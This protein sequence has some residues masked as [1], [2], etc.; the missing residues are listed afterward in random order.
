MQNSF[1]AWEGIWHT[2]PG[3]GARAWKG[4]EVLAWARFGR[5]ALEVIIVIE[6]GRKPCAAWNH[7]ARSARPSRAAPVG[8]PHSCFA[9]LPEA[10]PPRP[11]HDRLSL[12]LDRFRIFRIW[13]R[14][15]AKVSV[16]GR[17]RKN[18]SRRAES[19]LPRPAYPAPPV[20]A[21]RATRFIASRK[22]ASAVYDHKNVFLIR[23]E[24]LTRSI[25]LLNVR[26]NNTSKYKNPMR[27]R[28]TFSISLPEPMAKQ[29]E[30]AMKAEHRTRSELV[31]EALRA[32]FSRFYSR[33]P[34]TAPSR[35][36]AS[37]P[38]TMDLMPSDTTSSR[39]FGAIVPSPPI[40]MPR[41]P[42]FAKPHMA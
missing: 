40:R 10:W 31:R 22:E 23:P 6:S 7:P 20:V 12:F 35:H 27:T 21:P 18:R 36:V 14:F 34:T 32:A 17:I 13:R 42:K 4:H 8:Q 1:S 2:A 9:C 24:G 19:P 25:R 38:E 41:L 16:A 3:S 29:V 39:R 5:V 30:K 28:Q 33:I 37:V 15:S 26:K 11:R